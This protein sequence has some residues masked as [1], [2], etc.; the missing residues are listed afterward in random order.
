MDMLYLTPATLQQH[1]LTPAYI[2]SCAEARIQSNNG[3]P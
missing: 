1:F 2:W 3:M